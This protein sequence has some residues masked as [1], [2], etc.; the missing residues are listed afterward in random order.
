MKT[1][2]RAVVKDII[3]AVRFCVIA[4]FVLALANE[5]VYNLDQI[6]VRETLLYILVMTVVQITLVSTLVGVLLVASILKPTYREQVW[7]DLHTVAKNTSEYFTV[8]K[9]E[10]KI[11]TQNK[12]EVCNSIMNYRDT[13]KISSKNYDKL[14][15]IVETIESIDDS[16]AEYDDVTEE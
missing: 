4:A 1:F 9:K 13:T 8:G 2:R 10:K 5:P 6:N 12:E 3:R 14:T 15:C 11:E 16:G 7:K